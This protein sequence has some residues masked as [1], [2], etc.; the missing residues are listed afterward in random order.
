MSKLRKRLSKWFLDT[1]KKLDEDTVNDNCTTIQLPSTNVPFIVY[2]QYHVDKIHA[3]HQIA[4]ATL[5]SYKQCVNINVDDVICRKLSE[6]I[7]DEI[8]KNYAGDI[9]KTQM[10]DS[11]W[12]ESTLYSLDVYVCKPTKKETI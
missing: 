12:N 5:D 8:F 1:A 9:K 3:Q 10:A 2:D 6:A 11:P 4:N 7:A